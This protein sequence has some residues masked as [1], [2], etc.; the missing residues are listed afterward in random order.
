ME[1]LPENIP[2]PVLKSQV[3][4]VQTFKHRKITLAMND[5][6]NRP[7]IRLDPVSAEYPASICGSGPVSENLAGYLAGYFF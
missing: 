4:T 6:R 5:I 2:D 1:F 7:D 3:T